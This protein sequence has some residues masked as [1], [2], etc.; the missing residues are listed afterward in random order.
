MTTA[1]E[2]MSRITA[3]LSTGLAAAGR[4]R[5]R[6]TLVA[7]A[8]G[9]RD[10]A[11]ARTVRA[12]LAAVRAQRPGLR[13]RLGHVELNEPL[14]RDTLSTLTGEAV[15][16]PLL[17]AR[18]HHVTRDIPE[19]L[20]AAA[21]HGRGTHAE[22]PAHPAAHGPGTRTAGT[23][24]SGIPGSGTPARADPTTPQG[25]TAGGRPGPRAPALAARVAAPLGPHPLLAAAL[26]GRLAEAGWRG[27]GVVLAAAGSRA[28]PAAADTAATAALLAG[29]L[30]VPVLPAYASAAAPTVAEA[31]RA[32]AARGCRRIGV[33][34]C[35]TAPG[36]FAHRTAADA[37]ALGLTFA[38]P[39]GAH[40]ALA[41]LVLHRYDEELACAGTRAGAPATPA[42]TVRA[43]A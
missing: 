22:S 27:D 6:P 16:V 24:G 1:A 31:A 43:A 15:L 34:C 26:A 32:L 41:R 4:G 21:E 25:P 14:L 3:E 11:A 9:S 23:R 2:L 29:R 42:A 10:P 35:F 20:R 38:A 8:H 5:G 37:R 39:L 30:G 33:A 7:V 19:T 17:F 13:V 18:G 40:P 28:A 12:L 36:L